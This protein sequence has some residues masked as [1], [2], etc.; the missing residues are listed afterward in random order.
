MLCCFR[1]APADHALRCN[2][3]H[4]LPGK[5]NHCFCISPASKI[6]EVLPGNCYT[7]FTLQSLPL[8]GVLDPE[9]SL[10]NQNG[11]SLG[12]HKKVGCIYKKFRPLI[13]A[14]I[15]THQRCS[16]SSTPE[17]NVQS[18][19]VNRYSA[20]PFS[21]VTYNAHLHASIAFAAF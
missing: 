11:L 20:L 8:Y 15:L 5:S 18:G 19:G 13:S 10:P 14:L 21:F 7:K 16:Q 6:S 17:T 4:H 1:V 9:P 3:A 2:L 12:E